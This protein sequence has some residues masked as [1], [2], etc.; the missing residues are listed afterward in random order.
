[1]DSK[2]LLLV[3]DDLDT[4]LSLKDTLEFEGYIVETAMNGVEAIEKAKKTKPNLILLDV[5]MPGD[6]GFTVCFKLTTMEDTKDI[7]IVMLTAKSL[8]GDV[9]KALS[10]GAVS[11]IVKPFDMNILL[12]KIRQFIK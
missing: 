2:R 1:M 3:D 7:P 8:V 5:M 12:K 10:T 6:D 4:I 9:E 11:Y